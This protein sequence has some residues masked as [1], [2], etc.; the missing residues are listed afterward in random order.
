MSQFITTQQAK[1]F[2]GKIYLSAYDDAGAPNDSW[3]DSDIN[4]VEATIL[5]YIRETYDDAAQIDSD[6]TPQSWALLNA[7][8]QQLLLL[9]AHMRFD[10][11]EVPEAISKAGDNA[12]FR[13]QDIGKGKLKLPDI[14]QSP[15]NNGPSFIYGSRVS[16]SRLACR[17]F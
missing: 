10:Y 11:S 16:F 14:V 6:N 7:I 4:G 15:K 9:K 2:L 13:L 3:L 1:D 8:A 12:V 5:G 17:G